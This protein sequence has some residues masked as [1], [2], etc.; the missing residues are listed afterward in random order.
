MGRKESRLRSILAL[1]SVLAGLLPALTGNGAPSAATAGLPAVPGPGL[2]AV[3]P[4]PANFDPFHETRAQY[5]ARAQWLRDAKVGVFLHWNPSSLIGQEISWCRGA[6]GA[7]KYDRLYQQFKGERFN[8]EE[9]VRLFHEA[10]IRYAVIVPKHHDGFC[11]FDTKTSD[12]NV[13]HS[14]FGRDYVREMAQACGKSDV[15]FCLYYSVLDWWN[16]KYSGKAGADLTAYKNE[17]FKPHMQELLTKYGPVGCIWFDGHWEASWTHA[18]GREM[19]SY[20]RQLQPATLLGN[21]LDQKATAD[22]PNCKWTGSFFNGA[23]DPVGDYQAREMDIGKF[24]MDKAWDSCLNIS[25]CGWAWVPPMTVRPLPEILNWLIQCI[26]RDGNILLG[27]GPRPDGTIDPASAARLLEIGDWLKLNGEAVYGTRGGP[28]LPG[29]WGVSTRQGH[30]V[31]LFV[32]KWKDGA[33]TLPALPA[34]VKS[35]RLITRGPVSFE[36]AG[37]NLVLQVPEV[38]RRPEAT[39]IELTLGREAM[40]LP[41][42]TVPAPVNLAH[43]QPVAVSSV[44]PGREEKDLKPSHITDGD[45]GTT[46]AAEEK[47][48]DAWVTVELPRECEV[49]EAMLSDAPYGRT[50]AFDLE[51][52]VGGEWKPLAR[53]TTVGSELN[54]EFAPVRAR[55]FRLNIR[56]ASNTPTLA[57]FQLFG[58]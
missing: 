21:R 20:I 31:F 30:R 1:A 51:A 23:P 35:A 19:Y 52:Q 36:R 24:Y 53:G 46:W 49:G 18:D 37:T 43:G 44:W 55:L 3:R 34:E 45:P 41:L 13:M 2:A 50:Q 58:K 5:D 17:V 7:E 42:I 6:Y 47:A 57:E 4:P 39:I 9:W 29:K 27:V 26:G 48:R 16:P 25:S 8:A 32:T 11:M 15:R 33:L 40:T 14:P 38:F 54:L 56:K 22:G 12:Y 10:G 28:Y